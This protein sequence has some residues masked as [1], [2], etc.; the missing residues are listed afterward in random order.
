MFGAWRGVSA[1]IEDRL[2]GVRTESLI[3]PSATTFGNDPHLYVPLAYGQAR[4]VLRRL[5]ITE[6]DVIVDIGC[7][8]GRVVCLAA[9]SRA[10]GVIGIECDE[11]LSLGARANVEGLRGRKSPVQIVTGDAV[12]SDFSKATVIILFN[13]F[14]P[15][16]M[17]AVLRNIG[18]TLEDNP[19]HVRFAYV[20]P[21]AGAE[22]ESSTWLKSVGRFQS[23]RYRNT[24]TLW[25]SR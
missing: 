22:F 11:T 25:E 2:L 4:S 7:G 1:R 24:V 10:S 15:T 13:P 23:A 9:R 6:D 3:V 21:T 17:N 19:R 8:L 18:S 12:I 5:R 16:S 14:G 20:N